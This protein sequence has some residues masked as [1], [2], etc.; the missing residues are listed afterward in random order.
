[1]TIYF[2]AQAAN[3]EVAGIGGGNIVQQQRYIDIVLLPPSY[4]DLEIGSTPS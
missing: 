3:L 4:P 1:M 2:L